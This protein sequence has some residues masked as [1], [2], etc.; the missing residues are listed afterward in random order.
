MI[1]PAR[2]YA[3]SVL[4]EVE[5]GGYANILLNHPPEELD[6]RDL[7]LS[8]NLVYGVLENYRFLKLILSRISETKKIHPNISKII[9][10]ALY[11]VI[12]LSKIPARSAVNEAVEQAKRIKGGAFSG[13]V[14]GVLRRFLRDRE[15]FLSLDE[16]DEREGLAFKYS[17]PQWLSEMW[18]ERY[19]LEKVK[20]FIGNMRSNSVYIRTN[21]LKTD[22][23]ELMKILLSEGVNS[24]IVQNS[25][26]ALSVRS[27]SLLTELSSYRE[28]LFSFQNY[29]SQHFVERLPDVSLMLDVC[30]APGGKSLAYCERHTHSKVISCDIYEK[31]LS[32]LK[33]NAERLGINNIKTLINDALS[34][35][36][37][38]EKVFP[39][40][41]CD[42]PCSDLGTIGSKPE[43][44]L[45]RTPEDIET[46]SKM[47]EKILDI[48]KNY[49]APR[50]K[51]AFSTC[52]ISELE[53]ENNTESFLRKHK[54]FK[55][56]EKR[57][58]FPDLKGMHGFYF[59]VAERLYE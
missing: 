59:A 13:F 49:V 52:T 3:L 39:L 46:L 29:S 56:I 18:I 32:E 47:Q 25:D 10:L 26:T 14:N 6:K 31:K 7:L 43:I 23:D 4:C 53:N 41:V 27:S 19:G 30:A 2:S 54:D 1:S 5:N 40:V 20:D 33:S 42:V 51:L 22:R 16:F 44:L 15:K 48:S 38:W 28:G 58:L 9:C 45:R 36:A 17:L 57:Q 37:E 11:Q 50:G 21:T 12:F 55:L 34:Y 35:R 24:E 8:R